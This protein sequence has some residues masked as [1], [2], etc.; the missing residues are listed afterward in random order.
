MPPSPLT[1]DHPPPLSDLCHHWRHLH[2]GRHSG[3]VY[4][5][6]LGG[7]EE[8][9]AGQDALMTCPAPQPR[10]RE[11]TGP[12]P[13]TPSPPA[14][15]LAQ[16]LAVSQSGG[17]GREWVA[18][19]FDATSF[20]PSLILD[21][22]HCLKLGHPFLSLRSPKTRDKA[23]QFGDALLGELQSPPLCGEAQNPCRSARGQA[24][25]ISQPPPFGPT[26]HLGSVLGRQPADL[27]S[28]FWT[29]LPKGTSHLAPSTKYGTSQAGP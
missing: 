24:L 11:T 29:R 27:G 15:C 19:G 21:K 8:D 23:R 22:L 25:T 3:L 10:T 9:P 14:L 2:C 18:P 16:D 13:S 7:L 17:E 5:H 26:G 12:A 6:S 20:P 4:L 1:S 28:R